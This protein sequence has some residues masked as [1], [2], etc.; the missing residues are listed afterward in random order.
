M[1]P[2]MRQQAMGMAQNM[3][4]EQMAQMRSAA[5]ALTPEQMVSQASAGLSAQEQ[6]QYDSSLALKAEGNRLHG[7]RQFDAA[8]AKYERA[9]ENLS[10]EW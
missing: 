7:A 6:Y 10:S 1:S 5:A 9:V 8:V 4:P 2:E 3:T